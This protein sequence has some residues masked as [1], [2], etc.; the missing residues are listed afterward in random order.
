VARLSVQNMDE[1]GNVMMRMRRLGA[2]AVCLAVALCVGCARRDSQNVR[3]ARVRQALLEKTISFEFVE[4]PFAEAVRHISKLS[5][6]RITWDQD[7]PR[8]SITLRMSKVSVWLALEWLGKMARRDASPDVQKDGSV[9]ITRHSRFSMLI[10]DV[11][12]LIENVPDFCTPPDP[13]RVGL[14][15]A[16]WSPAYSDS[17]LVNEIRTL[18]GKDAWSYGKSIEARNGKLVIVQ[19]AAVHKKI[20]KYLKQL[21]LSTRY[22]LE[23]KVQL[24]TGANFPGLMKRL[25]LKPG[26]K[27]TGKKARKLIALVEKNGGR[28]TRLPNSVLRSRVTGRVSLR[29]KHS[30]LSY[31][32]ADGTACRQQFH[33]GFDMKVFAAIS[34]DRRLVTAHLRPAYCELLATNKRKTPRGNVE[35][36][37]LDERRQDLVVR[38]S[39]GGWAALLLESKVKD[40]RA[41]GPVLVLLATRVV[42]VRRNNGVPRLT[43]KMTTDEF[44]A[45]IRDGKTIDDLGSRLGTPVLRHLQPH[46]YLAD[47]RVRQD[48]RVLR[49]RRNGATREI[50]LRKSCSAKSDSEE[51]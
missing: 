33:T 22:D 45:A 26:R 39:R 1:E 37:V 43:S 44:I 29:R 40:K 3:R 24:M 9:K 31:Y 41:T 4:T 20:R 42:R 15:P 38:L 32:A 25:G 49:V 16:P 46:Y 34:R 48:G 21:R 7:M 11:Q 10:Y 13:L 14:T 23:L 8:K 28:T 30:Y 50:V 17:E 47:G 36:P 27:F 2:W 35:V 19:T 5:G 6:V 51:R 12:D 18:V